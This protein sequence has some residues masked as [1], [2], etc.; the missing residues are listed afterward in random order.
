MSE[1]RAAEAERKRL[2]AAID[3]V[4]EGIVIVGV[5]FSILYANPAIERTVGEPGVALVGNE[6]KGVF[7]R[8]GMTEAVFDAVRRTLDRG[9]SWSGRLALRSTAGGDLL[10][11]VSFSPIRYGDEMTGSVGLFKDVTRH[12]AMETRLLN[13]RKMAAIGELAGG[14]AHDF[15]NCL[16]AIS[17]NIELA[18]LDIPPQTMATESLAT[19]QA[20]IMRARDMVRKLLTFSRMETGGRRLVRVD[21]LIAETLDLFRSTCPKKIKLEATLPERALHV[22]GDPTQIGQAFLN[23]CANALHAVEGKRGGRL[24]VSLARKVSPPHAAEG[25]VTGTLSSGPYA[26]LTVTDNGVGMA[27]CLLE[28][29]YDPFF[30]TKDVDKGEGMGLSMVHGIVM[31]HSGAIEVASDV[32]VGSRFTIYLPLAE[33]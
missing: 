5:D 25:F 9:A 22:L 23:L 8:A 29:I 15:N 24:D 16:Q 21:R 18:L 32:G 14:V 31:A 27:P 28:R 4:E 13:E 17:G 1:E 10:F 7:V 2:D 30:T 12:V 19:A 33:A 20:A 11:D 6:A 3:A 26:L